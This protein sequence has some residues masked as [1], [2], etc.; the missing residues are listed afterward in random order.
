[1]AC[2]VLTTRRSKARVM[3]FSSG[4]KNARLMNPY[5]TIKE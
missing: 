4:V 3:L 2:R 1:L 5:V